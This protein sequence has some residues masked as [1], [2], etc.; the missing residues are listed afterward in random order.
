[1]GGHI[2]DGSLPPR[3]STVGV[4]CT[5]V[6][7]FTWKD[8]SARIT[9]FFDYDYRRV[10]TQQSVKQGGSGTGEAYQKNRDRPRFFLQEMSWGRVPNIEET[11]TDYTDLIEVALPSNLSRRQS[12]A[13]LLIG[14]FRIL[15]CAAG[16]VEP[17]ADIR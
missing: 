3:L 7:G 1:M 11:F 4:Q 13:A 8:P 15:E 14:F 6:N 12:R 5:E 9:S 16:I 10:T 2:F 17:I